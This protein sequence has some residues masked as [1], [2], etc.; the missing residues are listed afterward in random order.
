MFFASILLENAS[1]FSC[2]QV[3]SGQGV[4]S[5]KFFKITKQSP[6]SWTPFC[7][8]IYMHGRTAAAIAAK[9]ITG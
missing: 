1:V 5:N 6:D 8:N 4:N 3:F 2:L 9:K 7:G